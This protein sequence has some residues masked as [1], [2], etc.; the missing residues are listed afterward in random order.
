V[1][2]CSEAQCYYYTLLSYV[3]K[4]SESVKCHSYVSKWQ[5]VSKARPIND[6][7][8][9]HA[10]LDGSTLTAGDTNVCSCTHPRCTCTSHR[11]IAAA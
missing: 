9:A 6:V 5:A 8:Q 10:V 1:G 4:H 7:G 11:T 2:D 3:C